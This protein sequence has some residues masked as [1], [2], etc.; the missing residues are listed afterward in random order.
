M[1]DFGNTVTSA[2]PA[3]GTLRANGVSYHT[4]NPR[5]YVPLGERSSVIP[6]SDVNGA[7]LGFD[8][9][10]AGPVRVSSNGQ[11][12]DVDMA[13]VAAGGSASSRR[14]AGA[15]SPL[16]AL[17]QFAGAAAASPPPPPPLPPPA[18]GPLASNWSSAYVG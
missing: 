6:L 4:A 10:K 16:E 5:E 3:K 7:S 15:V 11:V 12:F 17:R 8:P 13:R 18:E 2:F 1:S 9:S 14:I